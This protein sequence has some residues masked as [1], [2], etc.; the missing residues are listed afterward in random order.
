[1]FKPTIAPDEALSPMKNYQYQCFFL[2]RNARCGY[3]LETPCHGASN[4][5]PQHMHPGDN[6]KYTDDSRYLDLAYLE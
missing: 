5:N 4:E 1:M 6:K 3:S 2:Y